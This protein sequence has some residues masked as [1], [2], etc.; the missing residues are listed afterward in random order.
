MSAVISPITLAQLE[1]QAVVQNCTVEELLRRWLQTPPLAEQHLAQETLAEERKLFVNGPSVV[2]KWHNAPQLPIAYVSPN[3]AQQFGYDAAELIA[4]S[5]LYDLLIHPDDLPLVVQEMRL[6]IKMG[7]DHFVQQ[8]RLAH[9]NGEYRWVYDYTTIVR[10]DVG[11]V[12]HFQGYVLDVTA[13]RE[14]QEKLSRSEA[15][16]RAMLTAIPD[17][18]FRIRVD[19]T[20]LDYHIP[21]PSVLG[22][23]PE[24]LLGRKLAEIFPHPAIPTHLHYIQYVVNTGEP[25]RFNYQLEVGEQVR[26]FEAHMVRSGAD[27]AL[28]IVRHVTERV[29]TEKKVQL[30]LLAL[31]TAANGIVITDRNGLIEWVNPAFTVLT[32]YTASEALGKNPSQLVKSGQHPP[33]FYAHMW[34]TIMAGQVWSGRTINRRKDGTLYTEEQTITPVS[35]EFGHIT[36]FIAIKQDASK[37]ELAEQMALEKERLLASL[38]KEQEYNATIQH[39]IDTLVHDLRTPLTVISVARDLLSDHHDRIDALKRQQKLDTIAQQLNYATELLNDLT[40]VAGSSLNHRVLQPHVL[41]VAALCDLMVEAVAESA[42]RNHTLSFENA[43]GVS[44]AVLDEVLLNRIL[45]NLLSNAIK[46]SPAGSQIKLQVEP[47]G[48]N[49][50]IFRVI[51]QGRGIA[52]SDLPHIFQLFYRVEAV[53]ASHIAGTGLGLSIVQ[54]CVEQHH[55]RIEV[56]STLGEGSIFTVRLP[57]N[58]TPSTT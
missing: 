19:G 36:H 24:Q 46:Y 9:A 6:N 1:E 23:R 47:D 4:Q 57:S 27:E 16:Q 10:D 55:G 44:T 38:K 53:R 51:D 58:L 52:E 2:F 18:M 49:W 45:I 34:Q 40:L 54:N 31:E 20:Y 21:N 12:K 5:A 17:M 29:Q 48:R 15:R 26:Y 33:E 8:Y 35:G 42:G 11:K 37:Q 39:V 30:H 56:E 32:G 43:T 25:V 13:Q 22:M 41:N 3:V 50:L 28:T 7:T 14:A